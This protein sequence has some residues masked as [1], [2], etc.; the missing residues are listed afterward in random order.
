MLVWNWQKYCYTNSIMITLKIN[1]AAIKDC[2]S[3]AL[4]VQCMELKLKMS[5]NI[6]AKIKKC[7]I[8][9]IV[10]LR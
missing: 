4:M 5:M 2:Y 3:Q 8:L 9:V 6:L 10:L 7:L 1:M